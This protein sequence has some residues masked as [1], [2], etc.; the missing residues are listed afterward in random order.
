MQRRELLT[1]VGSVAATAALLTPSWSQAQAQVMRVGT[2]FLKLDQAAAVEA[3]AGKVEVVE[4]F[5][6]SCPHCNAFEPALSQWVKKL[7]KD[8]VFRRVPIAFQSSF[9]PQQRLYYA[10]EAMG[11]VDKLHANVFAAIHVEKQNLSKAEAIVEWVAKQGVDKA[12]FVE[13]FNSFSVSTKATRAKQLQN[14]YRVEGVPA[15]GVAGRF[16]TDGSLAKSMDRTLQV[17]EFLISQVR[18]GH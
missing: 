12:K 6:Y 1:G 15:M 2:D 3:P 11:L 5:W 10:L 16:Y 14:A 8:V 18:S 7:P 9:V 13:Q 4:F 17:V